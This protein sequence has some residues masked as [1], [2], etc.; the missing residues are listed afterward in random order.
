MIPAG[1]K[2]VLAKEYGNNA[3]TNA[4]FKGY[5]F[6]YYICLPYGYDRRKLTSYIDTILTRRLK[7]GYLCRPCLL[8]WPQQHAGL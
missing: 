2:E 1:Y 5:A 6:L 7:S 3:L 8:A 4:Y